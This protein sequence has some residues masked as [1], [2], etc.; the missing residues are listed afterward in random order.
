LPADACPGPPEPTLNVRIAH[1]NTGLLVRVAGE[2]DVVTSPHFLSCLNRHM[3][4]ADVG[5]VEL[6]LTKLTF[7]DVVGV[8]AVLEMRDR[9]TGAGCHLAVRGLDPNRL[10]LAGALSLERHMAEESPGRGADGME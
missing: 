2:L 3:A 7:L 8:R 6:D 1:I 10:P 4:L 5:D 9:V